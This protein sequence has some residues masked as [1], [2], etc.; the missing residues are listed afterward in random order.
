MRRRPPETRDTVRERDGNSCRF[1]GFVGKSDWD[2][3]IHHL[4]HDHTNHDPDNLVSACP[5]CHGV[6]HAAH[7]GLLGR[8]SVILL[9]EMSQEA[10]S[11]LSR[12]LA[13]AKHAHPRL[14]RPGGGALGKMVE[15][16]SGVLSALEGR[17]KAVHDVMGTSDPEAFHEALRVMPDG[18]DASGKLSSLRIW[19]R[20][21]DDIPG[22]FGSG[23]PRSKVSGWLHGNGPYAWLLD[24]MAAGRAEARHKA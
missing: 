9:P 1:C 15:A 14:Y 8:A 12:S 17:A 2:I 7:W 24:D 4:D 11:A 13:V 22:R 6:H 5:H 23:T 19:L 21:D 16:R 10:L 18:V 3:E 20:L